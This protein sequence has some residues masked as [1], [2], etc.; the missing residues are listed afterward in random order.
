L[1]IRPDPKTEAEQ[2]D[3]KLTPAQL[4]AFARVRDASRGRRPPTP[5]SRSATERC[6]SCR[7]ARTCTGSI[8]K[9]RTRRVAAALAVAVVAG[10][11]AFVEQMLHLLLDPRAPSGR[12]ASP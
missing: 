5:G 12:T 1:P 9:Q 11:A 8:A 3:A 4:D 6:T 7:L 2:R 10:A